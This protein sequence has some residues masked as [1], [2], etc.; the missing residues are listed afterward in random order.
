MGIDRQRFWDNYL[1]QNGNQY[2]FPKKKKRQKIPKACSTRN[3][4]FSLLELYEVS[5]TNMLTL[6]TNKLFAAKQFGQHGLG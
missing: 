4:C 3:L 6:G 5:Q 1:A 2:I